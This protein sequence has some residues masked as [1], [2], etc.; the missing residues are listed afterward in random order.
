MLDCLPQSLCSWDYRILNETNEIAALTFNFIGEQGCISFGNADYEVR[1]HG[2]LSGHWSLERE[3]RT[4]ADAEKPNAFFR[5]FNISAPELQIVVK[6][7]SP[8]IRSYE[9]IYDARTV[10]VIRP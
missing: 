3:D 4:Y 8:L 10:G 1:K 7:I 2:W 6:A 9:I 5:R